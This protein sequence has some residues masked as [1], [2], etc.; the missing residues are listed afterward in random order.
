MDHV[1]VLN[2]IKSDEN[3]KKAFDY[4]C[5]DRKHNDYYFD[6]FEIEY[7]ENNKSA[8][9]NEIIQELDNVDEY[10]QRTA[11]SFFPPKTDLC[12]RRMIYIPFKD[13]VI[14]YA[15]VIV[16]SDLLD[17]EL[18]ERCFAN[19]RA[20]K[21]RANV[22]L[23]ENFAEES[24]PNFC[25]WQ[26]KSM[27]NYEVLL[28]T[29]IS[30]FYDSIS[31][32]YLVQNV[33]EL[34]SIDEN[35]PIITL[36]KKI[37]KVPV[38]SYS[39][40]TNSIYKQCLM[41]G[42]PIGNSTEGIL[43]NLF[44]KNKDDSMSRILDIEFGRYNDDMRIFGNDRNTVL[45]ALL[46]LQEL[47]LSKGL[48]LNASKTQIAEN[49]E[50][51]EKLRTK[52]Y[53]VSGLYF[54]E[55]HDKVNKTENV[56]NNIDKNFDEFDKIFHIDCEINSN[57]EAKE[58]CK[59]LSFQNKDGDLLLNLKDRTPLHIL[60]LED[61]VQNW[62]GSVRHAVWLL[63]Q[64]AFYR[65]VRKETKKKSKELLF[66]LLSSDN[67]SSYSKYRILH[68]LIKL[69]Q[70]KKNI[71]FRFLDKL[72]RKEKADLLQLIPFFLKQPAF[73]LNLI[74]LYLLR[75]F[76]KSSSEIRDYVGK[77]IIKPVGDP[78]KNALFYLMQLPDIDDSYIKASDEE[79]DSSIY[80]Y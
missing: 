45:S 24:W 63:V 20:K 31:H 44:L 58:Y 2:Y 28:R 48:N 65:G 41:Q 75:I 4:A 21:N 53:D 5:F 17:N 61:I 32:D 66:S 27:E 22:S 42:L 3:I 50:Q 38:V 26:K 74:S 12:F 46:I 40:L 15:F 52:F 33:S 72:S 79:Y 29:D 7:I 60:K 43:A 57:S 39:R 13:L 35:T 55:E 64:S 62:A 59:F 80:S 56:K 10:N 69:R 51:I 19:R 25:N 11:F 16:I 67:T 36:F 6:Y 71:Q 37:L 78:I 77:Y 9:I 30:S 47:L 73:E 23:L 14:R 8:I 70:T 49:V 34:L 18:S 68:H 1:Q 54:E 76:N